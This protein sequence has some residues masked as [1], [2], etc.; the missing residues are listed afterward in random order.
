MDR[1][2]RQCTWAHALSVGVFGQE[3]NNFGRPPSILSWPCPNDFFLYPKIKEVLKGRH[4]DN[5]ED[6]KPHMTTALK[7]VPEK[8]FQN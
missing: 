2:S 6:I 8:E 3:I 1:A 7:A 5:T 4:F